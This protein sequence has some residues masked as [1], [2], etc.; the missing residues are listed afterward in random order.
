MLNDIIKAIIVITAQFISGS[1]M[2]SY[3]LR[4][5]AKVSENNNGDGNPGVLNLWRAAG[6]KYGVA[7]MILDY[8]KGILPLLIFMLTGFVTDHYIISLAAVAGVA[9]HAFSPFLRFKGGKG[10]TT[11][12]GA[13]TVMTKWEG[14]VIFGSILGILYLLAK[15]KKRKLTA[16]EDALIVLFAF[17]GLML[18]TL[19]NALKGNFA[20]IVLYIGNLTIVIYKHRK[21]LSGILAERLRRKEP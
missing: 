3:H 21:E 18:Y 11:T 10:I 8:I 7:G 17:A 1:V 5:F 13:W 2:Y 9:G 16:G 12:F 19:I 15:N 20:L 14:P 4:K 6:W